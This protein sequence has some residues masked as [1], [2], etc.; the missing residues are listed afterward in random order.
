MESFAQSGSNMG[1]ASAYLLTL[2]DEGRLKIHGPD[3]AKLVEHMTNATRDDAGAWGWRLGK[4]A[5]RAK[6]DGCIALAIA[7]LVLDAND[8]G[9]AWGLMTV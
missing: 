9:A 1:A 8:D 7:A 6:I 5:S 3:S 2:V 4:T